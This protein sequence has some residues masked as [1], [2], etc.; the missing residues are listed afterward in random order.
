MKE[1]T[2]KELKE[3]A[4]DEILE[5]KHGLGLVK[6]ATKHLWTIARKITGTYRYRCDECHKII[7]YAEHEKNGLC[8]RCNKWIN[9]LIW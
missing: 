2:K 7:T 5:I 1:L 4:R 8:Q 9:S 6:T 3:L